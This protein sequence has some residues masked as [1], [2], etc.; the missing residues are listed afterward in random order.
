[1]QAY[2]R[3]RPLCEILFQQEASWQEHCMKWQWSET[4]ACFWQLTPNGTSECLGLTAAGKCTLFFR[5][6]VLLSRSEGERLEHLLNFLWIH[7]Q[8]LV[9]SA[10][11]VWAWAGLCSYLPT[12]PAGFSSPLQPLLTCSP[13]EVPPVAPAHAAGQ[14][15]VSESAV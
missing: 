7:G 15:I 10:E 4:S 2:A 9:C 8:G 14:V 11:R 5:A 3:K 6:A 1:M 13:R 12:T